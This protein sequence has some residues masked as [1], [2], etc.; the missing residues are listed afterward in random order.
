MKKRGITRREWLA[1]ASCLSL[2][3]VPACATQ[4]PRA[5]AISLEPYPRNAAEAL[6]RLKTGNRRFMD[7]K[8]IHTHENAS[9]RHQ[10]VEEQKPF[11]TVLGCSDSRVPP[12]MIFDVG[13][14][15]IFTIRLAGN[16]I[17][18]DVIGTL[19]YGVAHL[20]TPLVVVMGHE[21]CGAVTAT[22]EEMLSKTEELEHIEA[23]LALIRPGLSQL[24]LKLERKALLHAAVEANVRWSMQQLMALPGAAKALREKKVT[25]IGA[26]YELNTGTVRFL[27]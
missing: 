14:G 21:N 4:T 22:V 19:Q 9:W 1:G 13:F 7:N 18:E 25:L 17:A 2:A 3:L 26:V 6:L 20:H 11:A 16:I 27:D 10:L 12:E 24:D 15:D 5:G 23:L 8:S